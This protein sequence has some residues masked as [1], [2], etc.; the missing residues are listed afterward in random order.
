MVESYL[1]EAPFEELC[2]D[3]LVVGAAPSIDYIDPIWWLHACHESPGAIRRYNLSF[4]P[5]CGYL[6]DVPR[7]I[8]WS[9][10]FD[11]V[12]DFL[13]AFDEF[14]KALTFFAMIL[15]VFSYSHHSEKH[16]A[17]YDKLL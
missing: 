5:Y 15:S 9:T 12:F 17:I 3:S 4:D 11:Y 7:R 6:E 1:K 16:A 2:D 10:F 13:T 8:M 14:K